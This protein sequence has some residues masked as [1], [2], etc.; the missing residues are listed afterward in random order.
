MLVDLLWCQLHTSKEK[1]RPKFVG[2]GPRLCWVS[3]RGDVDIWC[4]LSQV[5]QKM[6]YFW[7]PICYVSE[8]LR[9]P[10]AFGF[11][12]DCTQLNCSKALLSHKLYSIMD[13]ALQLSGAAV[14]TYQRDL[15]GCLGDRWSYHTREVS[16]AMN[17][18]PWASLSAAI[19]FQ[20]GRRG[21]F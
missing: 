12:C 17:S 11:G 10:P 20:N 21:C 7:P 14:S 4:T 5:E 6:S 16:V 18:S 3:N 13:E 9:H 19:V 1:W 15:K 8:H 2:R